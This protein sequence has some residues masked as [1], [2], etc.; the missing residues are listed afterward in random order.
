[1]PK[2]LQKIFTT[3]LLLS[4]CACGFQVIYRD[5]EAGT[6]ISYVDELASIVIKKDRTKVSQDLKNSL[7][8]LFNPDHIKASPKYFLIIKVTQSASSTFTTSTGSSGRN[9][10][11]LNIMYELKNLETAQIISTGTT[12]VSDNYD[13]TSNRYGTYSAEQYIQTNLSQVA[14]QNIRNSLVNDFIET[15]KKCEGKGLKEEEDEVEEGKEKKEKVEFICPLMS[16]TKAVAPVKKAAPIKK[17]K[18][19]LSVSN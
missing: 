17:P 11:N 2:L 13:V 7:Y 3:F 15:R 6:D 16:E 19:K 8:D 1:M 14:A 4:L 18:K 12:T 9:R 10:V 5:R